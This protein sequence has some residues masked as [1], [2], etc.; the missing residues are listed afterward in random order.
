MTTAQPSAQRPLLR[1]PE[2]DWPEADHAAWREA[3]ITPFSRFARRPGAA[4]PW[5]HRPPRPATIALRHKAYGVFAAFLRRH[6]GA[7]GP[8]VLPYLTPAILDAYVTDQEQRGNR[9]VTIS[10][11][12]TNLHAALRMIAPHTEL[13]LLLRP[14]GRP[15]DKVFSRRPRPVETRDTTEIIAHVEAFHAAARAKGFRYAHGHVALRDAAVLAVIA[16]RAPRIGEVAAMQLGR[17]L[18]HKRGRWVMRVQA[19]NNKNHH[20]RDLP[21]PDWAQPIIDDYIA[22]ARP[23]LGGNATTAVWLSTQRQPCAIST[24]SAV[25]VRWTRKWFGTGRASHWMRKCLTT[26]VAN[27]HPEYLPDVAVV[28][29]HGTAVALDHYNLADA[30][31]AGR[32]HNDRIERRIAEAARRRAARLDLGRHASR[33]EEQAQLNPPQADRE[34]P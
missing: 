31:S 6:L 14:G 4:R 18:A 15:I 5:A 28:L 26:T 25:V 34:A 3:L 13:G 9:P 11:R 22:I 8:S 21:L 33:F 20:A 29:D 7:L 32:R 17:D 23:A 27:T 19:E 1:L 12:L 24:L 16:S 10:K 2:A 30:L